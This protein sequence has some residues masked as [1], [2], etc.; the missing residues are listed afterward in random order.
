[1][2][3]QLQGGSSLGSGMF[4]LTAGVYSP[5]VSKVFSP[6]RSIFMAQ[7]QKATSPR[8]PSKPPVQPPRNSED[9]VPPLLLRCLVGLAVGVAVSA[10]LFFVMPSSAVAGFYF[11]TLPQNGGDQYLWESLPILPQLWWWLGAGAV[12]GGICGMCVT[13]RYQGCSCD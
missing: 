13:Q 7:S 3:K 8:P 1:N 2:A 12:L 11:E 9:S 10:L 4:E 6:V 5:A